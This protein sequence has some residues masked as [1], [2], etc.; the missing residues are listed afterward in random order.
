MSARVEPR[1]PGGLRM[2]AS[3]PPRAGEDVGVPSLWVW[4]GSSSSECSETS[5]AY[6]DE[7]GGPLTPWEACPASRCP[8]MSSERDSPMTLPL[9]DQLRVV[10]LQ[11]GPQPARR[12]S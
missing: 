11:D 7:S 12:Q 9:L 10:S 5:S 3:V 4:P 1:G 8:P 6:D 2:L